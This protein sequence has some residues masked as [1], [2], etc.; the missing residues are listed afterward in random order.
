MGKQ[1]DLFDRG[2]PTPPAAKVKDAHPAIEPSS[3]PAPPD[4]FRAGD[5][6]HLVY[7]GGTFRA[8]TFLYVD[9]REA[10][11]RNPVTGA[12]CIN[13]KTARVMGGGKL[14]NWRVTKETHDALLA[15]V[16]ETK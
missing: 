10:V 13:M 3:M 14:G 7:D 12:Y 15:T 6:I 11:V 4:V 1:Q 16:G 8:F 9:K 2:A 5:T